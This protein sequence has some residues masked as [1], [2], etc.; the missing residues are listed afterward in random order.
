MT[1]HT[2][3]S[4]NAQSLAPIAILGTLENN[5]FDGLVR[6]AQQRASVTTINAV[7]QAIAVLQQERLAL[8]G[9]EAEV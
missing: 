1:T 2:I 9:E 5:L 7:N 3:E 8:Q 4:A 6:L